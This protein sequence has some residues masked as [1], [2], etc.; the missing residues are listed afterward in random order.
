MDALAVGR[1]GVV[2]VGAFQTPGA[3]ILPEALKRLLAQRP[4]VSVDLRES[5]GDLELLE[6]LER[7][8]LDLTFAV[9]P[10]SV[11]AQA[12]AATITAAGQQ[13]ILHI[14]L[15]VAPRRT[16]AGGL[17]LDATDAE[18][19]TY[20]DVALLRVP[21]AVGANNH[22]GTWGTAAPALMGRLLRSLQAH[23]LFFLDSVTTQRT[24]GYATGRSLGM[25]SRINNVF[26]D[27]N[28]P[29]ARPQLLALA[30]LATTDVPTTSS[31]TSTTDEP[32][33]SSSTT[34][35]ST[36]STTSTT[37][38][39]C[40]GLFPLCGGS[41]PPDEE[42]TGDGENLRPHRIHAPGDFE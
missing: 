17:A 22:E 40:G 37:M 33:T 6:Q 15:P 31:S 38:E 3:K 39:A 1:T 11:D 5:I 20:L 30:R 4:G 12:A 25:P 21:A 9:L 36:S 28:E 2:R 32:T 26:L 23:S 14:P 10:M 41:C 19:Q 16:A 35:S 18:I 7:G 24:I 27:G 13:E 42:C 34:T 29:S 8:L